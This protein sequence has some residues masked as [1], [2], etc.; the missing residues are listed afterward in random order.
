MAENDLIAIAS[1]ISSLVALAVSGLLI[2]DWNRTKKQ[3]RLEWGI[4]MFTYAIGHLIVCLMYLGSPSILPANVLWLWIYVNLGGAITMALILKGLLPLF[5][6]KQMYVYGVPIGFALIYGLGSFMYGFILPADN[7]INFI[8][9]GSFLGTDFSQIAN[10]SWWVVECLI[11]ASF[12]I[13]F[14][15]I[16]HYKESKMVSSLLISVHF[17]GYM[18][19][20]FIWPFSEFKLLFYTGRTVITT[21]LAVGFI[22]LIRRTGT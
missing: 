9:L 21:I 15:F 4:G 16:M 12:V 3:Q 11:P 6:E 1:L 22:D 18:L 2:Y 19:L 7:P 5:T 8:M 14:L 20:L 13:G 10:M 17:I